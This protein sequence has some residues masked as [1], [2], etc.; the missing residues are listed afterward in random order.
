M[1]TRDYLLGARTS[2]SALSAQREKPQ[3]INCVGLWL[4]VMRTRR[5]RSQQIV[6]RDIETE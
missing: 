5:P 1:T 3:P 4:G 2:P 6:D